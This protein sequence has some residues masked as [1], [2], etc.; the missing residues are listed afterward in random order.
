VWDKRF[1]ENLF[2]QSALAQSSICRESDEPLELRSA[3]RAEGVSS[4]TSPPQSEV[5]EVAN[6]ESGGACAKGGIALPTIFF[7]GYERS[8]K[9]LFVWMSVAICSWANRDIIAIVIF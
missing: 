4:S 7:G 9:E 1:K 3:R 8:K 6:E 5:R 2:F